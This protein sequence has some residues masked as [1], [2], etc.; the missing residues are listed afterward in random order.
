MQKVKSLTQIN[1][2]TNN[3]SKNREKP[4]EKSM[5]LNQLNHMVHDYKNESLSHYNMQDANIKIEGKKSANTTQNRYKNKGLKTKNVYKQLNNS[6]KAIAKAGQTLQQKNQKFKEYKMKTEQELYERE[7]R[8]AFLEAKY[9]MDSK[10]YPNII[11]PHDVFVYNMNDDN[12]LEKEKQ[13]IIQQLR[14]I[15][16]NKTYSKFDLL[17]KSDGMWMESE[18]IKLQNS[19]ES[20][21]QKYECD[22]KDIQ[23]ELD[24]PK[25]DNFTWTSNR[26]INQE[27]QYDILLQ[28]ASHQVDIISLDKIERLE[29]FE[30]DYNEFLNQKDE[31]DTYK[32]TELE[33]IELQK[34]DIVQIQNEF[35]SR[36]H[37]LQRQQNDIEIQKQKLKIQTEEL[38]R[39]AK[40]LQQ[41]EN[42]L[43][44]FES[45]I[46][47]FH[48]QM[49]KIH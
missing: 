24:H 4:D 49:F 9:N 2:R 16:T 40:Q 1:T 38:Q 31:F 18:A 23:T 30:H 10:S 26:L 25:T 36:E 46:G 13:D 22:D 43:K 14:S 45:K 20:N 33:E 32:Q 34:Q 42:K 11:V 19:H 41:R 29:Q 47:M 27:T 44:E 17:D 39:S 35:K 6:V 37:Q 8:I 3:K 28:D 21:L 48:N 15:D 7:Q 5:T 12:N